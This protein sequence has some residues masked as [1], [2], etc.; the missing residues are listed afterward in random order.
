M[1][2]YDA[3]SIIGRLAGLSTGEPEPDRVTPDQLVHAFCGESAT[4][5]VG[6]RGSAEKDGI[7][8]SRG[9]CGYCGG[10]GDS[11]ETGFDDGYDFMGY[12]GDRGWSALA[13]KGD[14]PFVVYMAVW[15][16]DGFAVA[17]YCETDLTITELPGA[18]QF[19]LFYAALRDAP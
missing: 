11:L 19:R 13:A 16:V 5:M 9:W 3:A 10:R 6:A 4:G 17:E 14:W 12:L 18:E 15:V 2:D 8:T 1:G 7:K